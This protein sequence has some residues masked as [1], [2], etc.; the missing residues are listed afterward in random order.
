MLS[1]SSYSS[2]SSCHITFIILQLQTAAQRHAVPQDA[3]FRIMCP[4]VHRTLQWRR[5][6]FITAEQVMHKVRHKNKTRDV[7]H[8]SF[9]PPLTGS[10]N[11]GLRVNGRAGTRSASVPGVPLFASWSARGAALLPCSTTWIASIQKE[12]HFSHQPRLP[13][14]TGATQF[15]PQPSHTSPLHN[16][17]LQLLPLLTFAD[18]G[19]GALPLGRG[20]A[21]LRGPPPLT[22][23]DPGPRGSGGGTG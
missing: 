14:S 13:T 7:R 16:G 3:S 2:H 15:S 22:M 1:H 21:L 17:G 23:P 5:M 18:R 6:L 10:A 9:P 20:P 19:T 12:I 4:Q 11:N 8:S